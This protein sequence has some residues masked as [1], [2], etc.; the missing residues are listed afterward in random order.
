[1]T[2]RPQLNEAESAYLIAAVEEYKKV[3]AFRPGE[4]N[5]RLKNIEDRAAEIREYGFEDG[6]NHA[7]SI[8]VALFK[9]AAGEAVPCPAC[10]GPDGYTNME[11][12]FDCRLCASSDIHVVSDVLLQSVFDQACTEAETERPGGIRR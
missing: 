12:Y 4:R 9:K 2:G 5:K 1:M 8:F 7:A 3:V 6:L 10:G 11:T